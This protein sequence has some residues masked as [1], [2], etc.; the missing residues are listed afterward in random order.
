MMRAILSLF[1]VLLVAGCGERHERATPSVLDRK[2]V[3]GYINYPPSLIVDPKTG[4]ISGIMHDL[5]QEIAKRG[6]LQLEFSHEL[7]W[8]TMTEDLRSGKVDI[9]CTGVWPN[10]ARATRANFTNAVYYSPVF[11]YAR[12][13]EAFKKLMAKRPDVNIAVI[14]G[15]TSSFIANT[16]FSGQNITSLPQSTEIAQL[17]LE[18][19]SGKADAT[20]MEPLIANKF[21]AA[22]PGKLYRDLAAA[23]LRVFPNTLMVRKE[24]NDLLQMLNVGLE[25]LENSG[26]TANTIRRYVTS[27]DEIL[28]VAKRYMQ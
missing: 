22:N 2:L 16:D 8:A 14:D 15:A 17:L 23:P 26:F 25:E 7:S 27:G 20:F 11:A 12:N 18:V 28:P 4:Q 1:I 6:N 21:I 9:V 13:Q 3:V 5:L 10:T 19:A 24:D